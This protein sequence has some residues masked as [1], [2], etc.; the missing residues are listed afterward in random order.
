MTIIIFFI[1]LGVLVFIHELGHFAVAKFFGVRV[2]E[3]G[4]GF[5]PRAKKLFSR[6][7]TDYTLNWIPFGG[8]VKIYG[9]DSLENGKQDPDYNRSM[10]AKPWWQQI[11][12]LIAGVTMN[13]LLAWALFSVAFMIGTPTTLSSVDNPERIK[14]TQLTVLSVVPESPAAKAGMT[15]GD[16]I[17]LVESLNTTLSGNNL[18]TEQVINTIRTTELNTPIHFQ[19]KKIGTSS[20]SDLLIIPEQ[21]IAGDQPAIGVSLDQV[22]MYR[23]GLFKSIKSGFLNTWHVTTQTTQAFWQLITGKSTVGNLTGPIG[24]VSV[25]GDAQKIG[26]TS[27]ITLMAVISI[28]LA[29]LNMMPFP[30]LDG[31]RVV[32]VLIEAITRKK[33]NPKIVT[34]VNGI[35]FMLLLALMVFVTVKDVIKLF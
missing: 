22:G 2:D 30:A 20:V 24:L 35:G 11:L 17:T 31:G 27:V 3:F 4:M 5:P 12:I 21:G 19:V 33:I 29:V 10:I 32:I 16:Q 6:N 28:N 13:V 18:S 8:F 7:G 14:D 34:W 1:I 26:F 25:V 9:E 23:E 15:A